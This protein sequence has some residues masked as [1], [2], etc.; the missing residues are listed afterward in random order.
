MNIFICDDNAEQTSLCKQ[1]IQLLSKKHGVHAKVKTFPSGEALLF[2][3]ED[4]YA[5]LDLVYLDIHMPGLNG[6]ETA[7]RLREIGFPGDIVFFT[8]SP[9]F[10]IAGYD[11]SALHYVV[12]EKT[13]DEKFEEIFLRA[14]ERKSRRESEV[15]VLTC[16]GESRCIPLEDIR[17]FEIQQRIVTVVYAKERFEFYS[18]M[19]RLEEQLFNRGFVR[20]HKSFLVSKRFI[21][22]IDSTRVLLDTGEE[23][24]VGKRYYAESLASIGVA[25]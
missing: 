10:A 14:C 12:K 25:S 19:M 24:P 17:Y 16:A 11:V 22:S 15:L 5:T 2:E 20:T 7:K 9:D 23:L 8:V 18:T 3:A 1:A 21:R 6:M 13:S 4:Q